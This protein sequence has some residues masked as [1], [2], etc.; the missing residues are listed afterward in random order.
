MEAPFKILLDEEEIGTLV[1]YEY[2]TPWAIGYL[3]PLQKEIQQHFI[4][5]CE[6]LAWLQ[7][8]GE[9]LEEEN[10][11]YEAELLKRH[12]TDQDV[13]KYFGGKWIIKS[14]DG[15]SYLVPPPHFY[16]DGSVEWRW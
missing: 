2:A 10:E 13:E 11:Q 6:Y 16:A 5:V 12:L 4:S 9:I 1:T 7:T 14:D 8:I 3:E 15:T